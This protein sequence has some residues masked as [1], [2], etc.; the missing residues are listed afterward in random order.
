MATYPK[1]LLET[2]HVPFPS[3]AKAPCFL[4]RVLGMSMVL[5]AC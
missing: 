5:H 3:W 2:L 1:T 4:P